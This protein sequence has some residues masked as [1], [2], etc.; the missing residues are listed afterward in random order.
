[1]ILIPFDCGVT[2]VF[3]AQCEK[4]NQR[5]SSSSAWLH[6]FSTLGGGAGASHM[7]AKCSTPEW[8]PRLLCLFPSSA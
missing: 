1:M 6:F 7:H 2:V 3:K 5:V 4:G 8:K